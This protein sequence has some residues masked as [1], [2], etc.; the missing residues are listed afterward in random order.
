M[1]F[2]KALKDDLDSNRCSLNDCFKGLNMAGFASEQAKC[3]HVGVYN[4]L[5]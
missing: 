2:W 1:G 3:A 5:R 4:R